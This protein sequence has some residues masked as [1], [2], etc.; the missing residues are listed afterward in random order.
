MIYSWGL[1]SSGRAKNMSTFK[2]EQDSGKFRPSWG[3]LCLHL[4]ASRRS[5]LLMMS[6]TCPHPHFDLII[7]SLSIKRQDMTV[8]K[9]ELC[10]PEIRLLRIST[11]SLGSLDF[12]KDHFAKK[13]E[14]PDADVVPTLVYSGSRNGTM[15]SLMVMNDARGTIGDEFN[16]DS[17]FGQRYHSCSGEQTKLVRLQAYTDREFPVIAC[18]SA[19]GLGQNWTHTRM[20]IQIG[21]AGVPEITQVV[22]RVGRNKSSGLAIIY[23]EDTR[24]GGLNSIE[25][26]DG[27]T[28]QTDDQ[29]MDALRWS[30][31]C[32]RVILVLANT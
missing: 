27:L 23:L 19:L 11:P 2:R 8:L 16:P 24:K 28:E 6:A 22:G 21:R 7:K 1:V 18:T 20:V 4:M 17:T 12:L 25:A 3:N 32:L 13:S 14:T 9:G 5:P 15:R 30:K 29:M 10:R 31:V 26:F